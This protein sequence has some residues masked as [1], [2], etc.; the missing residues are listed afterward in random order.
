MIIYRERERDR[1]KEREREKQIIIIILRSDELSDPQFRAERSIS[2][3]MYQRQFVQPAHAILDVKCVEWVWKYEKNISQSKDSL[4]PMLFRM[5]AIATAIPN[6]SETQ[7]CQFLGIAIGIAIF[8]VV[9]L[10]FY[11]A[12]VTYI[13]TAAIAIAAGSGDARAAMA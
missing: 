8:M 1:E 9:A 6:M 7:G 3:I 5:I 12:S 2:P 11:I 13:P 4:P 10:P